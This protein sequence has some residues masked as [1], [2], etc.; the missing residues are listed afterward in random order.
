MGRSSI[1]LLILFLLTVLGCGI[2]DKEF[3]YVSYIEIEEMVLQPRQDE[4]A[5]TSNFR[6]A[7]LFLEGM[8]NGVYELPRKI[9]V[10]SEDRSGE[11]DIAIQ[12]G[13]REN[14]INSQTRVYPFVGNFEIKLSMIENEVTT[15][16]PVFNYLDNVKF[17][18]IADFESVNLFDF[19]EDGDSSNSLKMSN[20]RAAFGDFSGKMAP[21]AD[22]FMEQASTQ[23]YRQIPSDG[24]PVFIE[25]DYFGDLDLNVGI[26]GIEAGQSFKEYFV[27]LRSEELWKK[28]YINI[29]DLIV[30]SKLDGYQIVLAVDNANGAGDERVYVDNIKLLHF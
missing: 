14:G 23:V 24:S 3:P 6:D 15:V 21:G 4:G 28:A 10:I 12:A 17:R 2:P 5:P 25:I 26:I 30:N 19:D 29:T 8:T 18:L 13:I 1:F 9:P 20:E 27:S 7:W 11:Y 22:N 16:K